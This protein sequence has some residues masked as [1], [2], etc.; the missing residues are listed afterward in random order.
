M[1]RD[2]SLKNYISRIKLVQFY[3]TPGGGAA[4]ARTAS[5]W[6]NNPQISGMQPGDGNSLTQAWKAVKWPFSWYCYAEG[7]RTGW[8]WPFSTL[9]VP[10]ESASAFCRDRPAAFEVLERSDHLSMVKPESLQAPPHRALFRNFVGCVADQ[11]ATG[12][13]PSLAGTADGKEF[14]RLISDLREKLSDRS[15]AGRVMQQ[16][17]VEAKLYQAGWGQQYLLPKDPRESQL[18]DTEYDR[19]GGRV[20]ASEFVKIIGPK[21][22][23]VR[24]IWIGFINVLERRV[25]DGRIT[26]LRSKW[27]DAGIVADGDYAIEVELPEFGRAF[28]IGGMLRVQDSKPQ[29]RLKGLLI[30]P[31]SPRKCQ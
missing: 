25:R 7:K 10:Q 21:A 5:Y 8:I 16:P 24:P 17:A 3:G 11:I 20:F 2:Q 6:S 23:L 26:E 30:L 4:I 12:N 28:L 14:L 18:L 31:L 27:K 22:E 15:D 13:I 19:L 9:V 1:E 29:A